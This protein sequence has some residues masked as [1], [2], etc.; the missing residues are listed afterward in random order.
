MKFGAN[1]HI[2]IRQ[3]KKYILGLAVGKTT[4]MPQ[5][6]DETVK[7]SPEDLVAVTSAVTGAKVFGLTIMPDHG[8]VKLGRFT[9][10]KHSGMETM[11]EEQECYPLSRKRT[12]F[13]KA[14]LATRAPSNHKSNLDACI[15]NVL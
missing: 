14:G 10:K 2:I 13:K 3:G 8:T 11:D 5:G 1:D 7:F 4:I 12:A 15:Q 9:M 6:S